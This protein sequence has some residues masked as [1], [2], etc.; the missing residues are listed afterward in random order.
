[1]HLP[2]ASVQ[3]EGLEVP[4]LHPAATKRSDAISD[5]TDPMTAQDDGTGRRPP[6]MIAVTNV[7]AIPA[8]GPR[9]VRIVA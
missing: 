1:M 6:R 2:P 7:A 8:L 3:S 5:R 4:A 9:A